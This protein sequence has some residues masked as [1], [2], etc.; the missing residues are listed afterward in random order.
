MS[1]RRST[2]KAVKRTYPKSLWCIFQKRVKLPWIVVGTARRA[3][4]MAISGNNG[5][6]DYDLHIAEYVLAQPAQHSANRRTS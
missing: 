6:L 1:K 3:H 4:T 5:N 2:A